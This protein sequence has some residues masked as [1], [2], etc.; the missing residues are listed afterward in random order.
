M[1][2]GKSACFGYED[3]SVKVWDLKE[4]APLVTV[5]GPQGHTEAVTCMAAH[6]DGNLLVTGSAD[7]TAKLMNINSGKVL[8]I[9]SNSNEVLNSVSLSQTLTS[10][11]LLLLL[12]SVIDLGMSA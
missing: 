7:A 10:C 2:T 5:S 8:L 9:T 6:Q 12:S 1:Y 3:G 4:G 11:V